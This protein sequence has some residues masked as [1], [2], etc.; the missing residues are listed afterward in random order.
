M[1]QFQQVEVLTTKLLNLWFEE[2][3]DASEMMETQEAAQT[4]LP[5]VCDFLFLCFLCLWNNILE[6]VILKVFTNSWNKLREVYYQDEY[7]HKKKI[8]P[9]E[10]ATN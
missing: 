9:A 4:L 6:K 2:L 1:Q 3:C 8:I 5:V 10:K 7:W